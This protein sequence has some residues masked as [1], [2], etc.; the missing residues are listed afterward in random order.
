MSE[1]LVCYDV[2]TLCRSLMGSF[3]YS[4]DDGVYLWRKDRGGLLETRSGALIEFSEAGPDHLL[5]LDLSCGLSTAGP[6][7]W[8][9]GQ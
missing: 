9:A 1:S 6:Y 8:A 5:A 4:N 7:S 3:G 2:I